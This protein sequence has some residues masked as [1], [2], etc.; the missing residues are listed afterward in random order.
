MRR[1]LSAMLLAGSLA[2][3]GAVV[4]V[5]AIP[6]SMGVIHG[7]YDT[8]VGGLRVINAPTA[9]CSAKETAIT[10]NQ[11]GPPGPAGATGPQGPQGPQGPAGP[12]GS[13]GPQGMPGIS[14]YNI[15]TSIDDG[16]STTWQVNCPAGQLALGGGWDN[17]G[18]ATAMNSSA[19]LNAVPGAN[20]QQG[21]I[22][23]TAPNA[24]VK[25]MMVYAICANVS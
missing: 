12:Q 8:K 14:N 21:W 7:C 17:N 5:A 6:D 16:S 13:P 1:L 20:G 18:N 9:S 2:I 10:W 4:A 15:V 3:V 24:Y 25:G 22:V 23:S 11:T 19:P